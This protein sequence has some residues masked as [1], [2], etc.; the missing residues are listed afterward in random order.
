[1]APAWGHVL[2]QRLELHPTTLLIS[3]LAAV[4]AIQFFGSTLLLCAV[5]AIVVLAHRVLPAWW[6]YVFR[7]RWLILALWLILAYGAPGDALFDLDW[8]PTWEGVS[9][10]NLQALRLILMLGC[11]AW[12]FDQLGRSGLIASLWGLLR[13][14]EGWGLESERLVV[15][16]S[17]VLEHLKMPLE[18]SAWRHMLHDQ[19]LPGGPETLRISLPKW[20]TF[21][22]L[23]VTVVLFALLGCVTL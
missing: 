23:T 2:F 16:L 18:K 22:T 13:P 4:L 3:W 5:L 9:A 7:A 1:M 10:G 12:L 11:L 14:L 20:R 8:A 17:L 21:D 15:R 6:R 19:P